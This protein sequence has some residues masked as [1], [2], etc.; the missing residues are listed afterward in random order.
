MEYI[1]N[2]KNYFYSSNKSDGLYRLKF[3]T[4]DDS[5]KDKI[6][7]FNGDLT[8]EQML[9]DFLFRTNSKISLNP[10]DIIFQFNAHI[11]NR[12]SELS[13]SVS[14]IFKKTIN[15][16]IRVQDVNNIIGG[17]NNTFRYLYVHI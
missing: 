8:V 4:P 7:E 14:Q 5:I 17:K 2:I 9:K 10:E 6:F 3:I 1:Y 12:E 11:L 13:K 16:A 15:A